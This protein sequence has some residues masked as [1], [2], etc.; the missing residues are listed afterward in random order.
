M[1]HVYFDDLYR[2]NEFEFLGYNSKTS[3]SRDRVPVCLCLV[4]GVPSRPCGK[5]SSL[6]V[7]LFRVLV[8]ALSMK[9][10]F[11]RSQPRIRAPR[12]LS[13]FPPSS[14]E[15]QFTRVTVIPPFKF[16]HIVK[17]RSGLYVYGNLIPAL[18]LGGKWV[19]G[20]FSLG[21]PWLRVG[22]LG[23]WGVGGGAEEPIRVRSAY[24]RLPR[25]GLCR[26]C[27]AKQRACT[28]TSQS[29]AVAR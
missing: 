6:P 18:S 10:G 19:E 17:A 14:L 3:S 21:P 9:L 29:V 22:E 7:A 15:I 16:F 27:T 12:V 26:N 8:S 2:R 1:T 13:Q 25:T 5:C 24:T 20:E 28:C 11:L 23:G 4:S